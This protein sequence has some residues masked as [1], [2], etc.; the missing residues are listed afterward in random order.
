MN[1]TISIIIP[2]KNRVEQL[3]KCLPTV[4]SQTWQDIQVI[5]IDFNCP[6]LSKKKL[7]QDIINDTRVD[8]WPI[9]VSKWHWNLAESRN[10]GYGFT[11]GDI[12]LFLDAD[13]LLEPTFIE[14]AVKKLNKTSFVTGLNSPPWNGC[15]CLMV[16]KKD[17][18]SVKGYN[19][20]MTGWGMEDINMYSRLELM[21]LTH[22]YFDPNLI[23][24]MSHSDEQRNEYHKGID[25]YETLEQN[26]QIHLSGVFKSSI[27]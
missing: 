1:N 19:E 4:L 6:V 2:C 18:Y 14:M 10:A 16:N 5:V 7:P 23:E 12:L 11:K 3:L 24:N 27:R 22:E 26:N 13:T 17:F 20:S 9:A 8:V 15:G 21:G 25:K